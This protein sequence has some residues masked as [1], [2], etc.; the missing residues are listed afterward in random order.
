[1]YHFN[2][3]RLLTGAQCSSEQFA[4]IQ[5]GHGDVQN[6]GFFHGVSRAMAMACYMVRHG[7]QITSVPY[8]ESEVLVSTRILRCSKSTKIN[9]QANQA[10]FLRQS[11]F[12]PFKVF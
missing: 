1:M 5:Y 4:S 7:R 10:S 8:L 12:W 6:P 3:G 9:N 11:A 2:F